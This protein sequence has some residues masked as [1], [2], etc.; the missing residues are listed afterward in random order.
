MFHGVLTN[1][2]FGRVGDYEHGE[3]RVVIERPE[4][5]DG[6]VHVSTAGGAHRRAPSA[7]DLGG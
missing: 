1:T 2:V 5:R 6:A 4:T 3:V 7:G